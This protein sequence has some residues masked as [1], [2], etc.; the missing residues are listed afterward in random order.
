MKLSPSLSTW[1]ANDAAV[2][3]GCISTMASGSDAQGRQV[4]SGSQES[5][6]ERHIT[7][8]HRPRG[9]PTLERL[10]DARTIQCRD[11]RD[12]SDR[13]VQRVDNAPSDAVVDDFGYRTAIP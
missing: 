9:E 11:L 10:A 7:F 12:R 6:V 2:A 3:A 13:F 8:G 1:V 4:L 5:L